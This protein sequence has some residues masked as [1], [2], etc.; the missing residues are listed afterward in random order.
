MLAHNQ[1]FML[2]IHYNTQNLTLTF[3][4][5]LSELNIDTLVTRALGNG[6]TNFSLFVTFCI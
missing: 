2:T 3:G 6:H 5:H 1:H 4:L